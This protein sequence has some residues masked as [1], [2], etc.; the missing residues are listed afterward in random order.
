MRIIFISVAVVVLLGI[1]GYF[2]LSQNE[3]K[4]A[5]DI[6]SP[7]NSTST[8]VRKDFSQYNA[9]FRFSAEIPKEFGVEY[10]EQLSAISIYDSNQE[11]KN[12]RDK[13]QIYITNFE[14]NR[15]LT[16][17][18]VDI[19]Q[20][21]VTT[22]K[23]RDA[24]L[25]EITKKQGVPDF[26]SQPSWRNFKHKVLDIRFTK[27]NPSIFYPFAY[28][29]DLSE[30]IFT[31]FIDSL[32]FHNDKQSLMPPLLKFE[33]RIIKK[34]FGLK[35]SP[36]NSPVQPEN[37]T[38]YHT[39]IDYEIF[40]EE[41]NTNV[42][43]YALCGGKLKTKKFASGYGGVAVQDCLFEDEAVTVIYGHLLFSSIAQSEDFYFSPGD[44]IGE[45]AHAGTEAGGERKHLHIGIHKG[46]ALDIRGYVNDEAQLSGWLD[47]DRFLK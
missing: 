9:D 25:Y 32:V 38:G 19:S 36:Q 22:I 3:S 27:N 15:F 39:G 7:D 47:P 4:D 21:I 10:I 37:F 33:E 26:I 13:A 17:R 30:E 35:V 11:A 6:K 2:L 43:A 29:P 23:G 28:N 5:E 24:I 44:I 42:P 18:T 16:L 40:F 45:L 14:A 8:F 31:H 1:V 12:I 20:Q 34:P 41:A 46:S